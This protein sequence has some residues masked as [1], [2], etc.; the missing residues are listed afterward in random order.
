[1]ILANCD[2]CANDLEYS[3]DGANFQT[4]NIFTGLVPG[5]YTLT[6]EEAGGMTCFEEVEFTVGA[7]VDDEPPVPV[8]G[9][10]NWEQASKAL[11]SDRAGGDQAG[12]AVALSE[13]YAIVGARFNDTGGANSQAG[14]AYIFQLSPT[15]W[16]E[17]VKLEASDAQPS[18]QFG[19]SV[20]ISEDYAVVGAYAEDEG[21][22]AAGAV[23]V[24]GR[25]GSSW[26]QQAKLTASDAEAEDVFGYSVALHENTIIVGAYGEDTGGASAGAAYIFER[27][28]SNW[29]EQAKLT[30]TDA[31]ADDRFGHSVSIYHDLALVGALREDAGGFNSG[32][33]YLF[34]R[35]GTDWTQ[36]DKFTGSDTDEGDAF[37]SRRSYVRRCRDYWC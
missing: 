12:N 10:Y 5:D 35:S 17:Q 2:N 8:D 18:D 25:S 3:I 31:E 29:I 24:F 14:G 37:G 7:G 9:N 26:V 16:A 32:A 28:G 13:N 23:Y 4:A 33:A 11:M 6:V 30:A 1:M 34:K 22:S 19:Q 36:T 27:S 20:A 21:G 15:G